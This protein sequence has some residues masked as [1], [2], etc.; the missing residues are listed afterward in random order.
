MP[1]AEALSNL[2]TKDDL[3]HE[4]ELV[5]RDMETLKRDITIRLGG[6]L[7]AAT[8]LILTGLAIAAGVLARLIH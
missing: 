3:R 7:L 6:M 5:R 2:A 4:L 8:G 1:F